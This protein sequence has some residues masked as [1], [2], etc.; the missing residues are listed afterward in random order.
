MSQVLLPSPLGV[1][2]VVILR[3]LVCWGVRGWLE[4][5][6]DGRFYRKADGPLDGEI[7]GPGTVNQLGADALEGLDL[8]AREGDA[9]AVSLLKNRGGKVSNLFFLEGQVAAWD[10]QVK[11]TGC[12]P[13]SLSPFW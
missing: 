10:S 3:F 5:L 2:R 12:S 1:L 8:A 4:E 13:K 11:R 6:V 9:D 7:L